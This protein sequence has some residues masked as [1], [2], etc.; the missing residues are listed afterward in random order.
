MGSTNI[1]QKTGDAPIKRSGHT[2]STKHGA[3]PNARA[4]SRPEPRDL[5]AK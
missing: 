4:V 5:H 2:A 1:T 3:D